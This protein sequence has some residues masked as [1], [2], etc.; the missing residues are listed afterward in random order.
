VLSDTLKSHQTR[1]QFIDPATNPIIPAETKQ[2]ESLLASG[3][4]PF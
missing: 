2:D 4:N 3:Q 1:H